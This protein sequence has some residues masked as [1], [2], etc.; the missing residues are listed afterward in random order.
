[1]AKILLVEDERKKERSS[2][3]TTKL[4]SKLENL[5]ATDNFFL[6]DSRYNN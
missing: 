5:D 6:T 4:Y 3:P 1:M 2:N